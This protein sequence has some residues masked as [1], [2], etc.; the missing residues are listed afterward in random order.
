MSDQQASTAEATETQATTS[1]A[2]EN[3]E[4]VTPETVVPKNRF[5]EVAKRAY[6]AEKKL[7]AF[8]TAQA[9]AEEA[10]LTEQQKYAQLY[11]TEKTKATTLEARMAELQTTIRKEKILRA[12]EA[13]ANKAKFAEPADAF[14]F[15]NLDD[16]EIDEATGAVKGADKLVKK[17][18][19]AKP[20][21]L[22][23][24]QVGGVPATP[25][26]AGAAAADAEYKRQLERGLRA[27]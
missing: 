9:K 15:I 6:D 17:L 1:A 5:D 20:Y 3:T 11:E 4:T 24:T 8:E 13:E 2:T 18:A 23:Q 25:K 21:L 22:S 27:L 19:E 12:V 26:P 14:A 16:I 7:K 10:K